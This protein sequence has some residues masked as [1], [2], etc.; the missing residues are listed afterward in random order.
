[1]RKTRYVK[2]PV[3]MCEAQILFEIIYT[4]YCSSVV[5]FNIFSTVAL[6]ARRKLKREAFTLPLLFQAL[7]YAQL[8]QVTG[9][10]SDFLSCSN[11][12]SMEV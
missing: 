12:C 11:T 1:M 9:S 4:L 3:E 8:Q 2:S 5:L 7:N 6:H 10:V